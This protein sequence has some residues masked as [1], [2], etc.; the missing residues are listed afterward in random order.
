MGHSVN[1]TPFLLQF[2]I[3]KKTAHNLKASL[4]F[5]AL[6]NYREYLLVWA[7]FFNALLAGALNVNI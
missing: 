7:A 2:C 5:Q 3:I 1:I 4:T 6:K